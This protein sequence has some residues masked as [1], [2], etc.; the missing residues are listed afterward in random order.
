MVF[1]A[2]FNYITAISW[3]SVLVVEETEYPVKTTHHTI[4]TAT[5]PVDRNILYQQAYC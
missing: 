3:R 1:E 4:T 2:T 5:P